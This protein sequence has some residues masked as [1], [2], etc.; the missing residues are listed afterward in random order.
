MIIYNS[1]VRENFYEANFFKNF[2]YFSKI[3]N[4]V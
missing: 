2:I 3:S 4:L 1:I